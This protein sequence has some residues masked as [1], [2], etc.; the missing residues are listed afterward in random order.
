[1]RKLLLLI[2]AA[3]LLWNVAADA[4]ETPETQSEVQT[5]A[6]AAHT[7]APATPDAPADA[8]E[9]RQYSAHLILENVPASV[10]YDGQAVARHMRTRNSYSVRGWT[11]DGRDLLFSY[12]GDL[13]RRANRN[14][15]YVKVLD[16]PNLS[17]GSAQKAMVCGREGYVFTNDTDGDEYSAVYVTDGRS[18]DATKLSP[19]RSRNVSLMTSDAMDRIAYAS[20][21]AGTGV[22]SLITQPTCPGTEPQLLYRGDI[23]FYPQD[24]S[25]NATLL[26][27]QGPSGDGF[28]LSEIDLATGTETIL[29]EAEETL[30]SASYS[31]DGRYVFFTT[32]AFSNFIE[33]MRLDRETGDVIPVLSDVGLDID[34]IAVSPDRGRMAVSFNRNGL[35]T[36]VVIDMNRLSLISG[37]SRR[38]P[39]VV[40]GMRFSPDGQM[41]ALRVSQPDVPWRSGLYDYRTE[42]FEPWTGGF[43]P[44]QELTSLIPDIT[45]YP[46][47]DM[48]GDRQRRIPLLAYRPANA[49]AEHPAPV[50]IFAHG[51]PE[52]QS[53]PNFNRFYHYIVTEMGIAVLRPNIRGSEGY[54][55]E[56]EQLDETV[57]RGDAIRDIGALL[58]W[59]REQPDLDASRVVIAGGSYGGFVTLAS[60]VAYPD[61]FAGGISR[62]GVADFASFMANTEPYRLG[63]R[64]REY[65][66]ERDPEVARFFE[67]ISPMRHAD[68]IRVPMLFIQGANDPR[69]PEQQSEDMIAAIRANGVRVSYVLADNEGH[70][71]EKSENKVIS[72]GA[73]IAFLREMLLRN[74]Q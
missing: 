2:S 29:L 49:S 38:S 6:Q 68:R 64:R 16:L 32:N 15:D 18:F 31:A 39:G 43:A 61:R 55:K 54:G 74:G 52:S 66:D 9:R 34:S 4:Q 11:H 65:G 73:Q 30:R 67:E 58:D 57:R 27:A 41:L 72:D 44:D 13:Y 23:P 46:T 25:P 60:L 26:L 12:R 28:K 47:F 21:E 63:N 59:I 3:P 20:A 70:G 45:S 62:F 37:P 33:L 24:F 35:S 48:D 36:L 50:V 14:A 40:E 5:Q 1:M 51:G 69:V 10:L 71:F 8:V 19:G 7:P 42:S 22:W 56:F 53:L 17:L